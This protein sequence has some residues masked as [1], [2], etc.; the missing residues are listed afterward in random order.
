MGQNFISKCPRSDTVFLFW[1]DG[2]PLFLNT[3]C[4]LSVSHGFKEALE[5][6]DTVHVKLWQ[7]CEEAQVAI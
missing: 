3:V 1:W 5:Q 6:A 2:A 7:A 4:P